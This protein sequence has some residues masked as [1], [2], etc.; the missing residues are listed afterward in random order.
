MPSQLD[1]QEIIKRLRELEAENERLR[2]ASA[3]QSKAK[4]IIVEGEYKGHPTLTFQGPFRQF[5]LGLTKIRI[6]SEAWPEVESFL[7]KH[8]NKKSELD[9]EKGDNLKI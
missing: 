7:H 8:T 9:L 4:L 6:L 3:T 2:M 1:N 5:T